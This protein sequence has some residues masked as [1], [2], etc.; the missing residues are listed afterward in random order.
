VK[1]CIHC[2]TGDLKGCRLIF[3]ILFFKLLKGRGVEIN[4]FFFPDV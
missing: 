1:G 4:V 2:A 3:L